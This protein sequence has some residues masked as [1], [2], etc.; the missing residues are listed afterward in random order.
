MTLREK[1]LLL[2]TSF[3]Y[4]MNFVFINVLVYSPANMEVLNQTATSD[5]L[6]AT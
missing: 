3:A 4:I 6:W 1:R 2:T 5:Q